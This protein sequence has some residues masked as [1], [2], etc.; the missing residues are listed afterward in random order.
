MIELTIPLGGI[1]SLNKVW[2]SPH[3]AA[4]SRA[5]AEAHAL[6]RAAVREQL[7]V[8]FAGGDGPVRV[9]ITAY[10]PRPR[11][12]DNIPK[13]VLDG[14]VQAG[15]IEDDGADIVCE[16]V[17]RSRRGTPARIEIEIEPYKEEAEL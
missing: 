12:P 17:L 15:V 10:A 1:P 6:I 16:L 5:A 8:E 11:D 9:T 13:L 14:L 4:R 3:W 2:S 7:G